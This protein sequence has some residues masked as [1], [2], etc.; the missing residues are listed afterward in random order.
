MRV[1]I[2]QKFCRVAAGKIIV[3][4]DNHS[5]VMRDTF[6]LRKI[7]VNFGMNIVKRII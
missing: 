3:R 4:A 5:A 6:N 1:D 7:A 2:F